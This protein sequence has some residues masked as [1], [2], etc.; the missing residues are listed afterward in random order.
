MQ[1]WFL[2]RPTDEPLLLKEFASICQ[3]RS[4]MIHYNGNG[5][6][7]PYL[8]HKYNFYQQKSPLASL[9]SLDLYRK[10]KPFQNLFGLTSVKQ[11]DVE[12][13]LKVSRT[14]IS[15]GGELIQVYEDYLETKDTALLS[16]LLQH[17]RDDTEGLVQL[18]SILSYERIREGGFTI[19]GA[20]LSGCTLTLTLTLK[21][22]VPTPVSVS[23]LC[24][25][26]Q[27]TETQGI[28]QIFG[29]RGTMKHFFQDY[30][31]YYYL[32]LEDQ[33]IHKSI[34]AFVDRAHREKAKAANCYQKTQ[35][36]FLP[37]LKE[38]FKPVFYEAY[39]SKPAYFA[40]Q[41]TLLQ[42]M[43]SLYIYACDYLSEL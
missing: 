22:A 27:M 34:G 43:Q 38:R 37:Q 35:G 4:C 29:H 11:K 13:F 26:L 12:R 1:Q 18:L 7:I 8:Q 25:S 42:D 40:Y 24:F 20:A 36:V 32:P 15:T 21:T 33:A 6:D 17:N 5:F 30:K 31:N 10:A 16:V 3:G 19:R 39:K 23:N 2:D 28:L 41:E 9:N 14:D